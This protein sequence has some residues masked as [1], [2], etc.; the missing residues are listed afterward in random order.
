MTTRAVSFRIPL[1]PKQC[2]NCGWML[3]VIGGKIDM[4]H[5]K[6][7]HVQELKCNECGH[8]DTEVIK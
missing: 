7:T 1:L 3:E 2:P 5:N 4:T 8:K 6:N